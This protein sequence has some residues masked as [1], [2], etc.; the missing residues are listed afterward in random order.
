MSTRITLRQLLESR[1][2][3]EASACRSRLYLVN[4]RYVRLAALASEQEVPGRSLEMRLS[5]LIG[6]GLEKNAFRFSACEVIGSCQGHFTAVVTQSIVS[7]GSVDV[8][9]RSAAVTSRQLGTRVSAKHGDYD[10]VAE[11]R[12]LNVS[13]YVAL[14]YSVL[15]HGML[16]FYGVSY[17]VRSPRYPLFCSFARALDCDVRRNRHASLPMKGVTEYHEAIELWKCIHPPPVI[18][19][20][21]CG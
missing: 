13:K 19:S 12:P 2:G 7:T 5:G 8:L 17:K 9:K 18:S 3:K 16:Y 20:K 6:H 21:I 1:H 15:V 4:F 11:V 14:A 10:S